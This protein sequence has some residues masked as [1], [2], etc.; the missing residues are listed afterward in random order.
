M[1]PKWWV[2]IGFLAFVLLGIY[3]WIV[4]EQR[5]IKEA[6]RREKEKAEKLPKITMAIAFKRT[7][8]RRVSIESLVIGRLVKYGANVI[9]LNEE[10]RK[11]LLDKDVSPLPPG[12][13]AVV[14]SFWESGHDFWKN[15]DYLVINASGKIL[16]ADCAGSSVE[17]TLIE[18]VINNIVSAL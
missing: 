17:E 11:K 7:D 14:G 2:L 5:K 3:A 13:I 4:D 16:L 15:L 12:A 6:K 9:S 18:N 8:G 10:N 1:E